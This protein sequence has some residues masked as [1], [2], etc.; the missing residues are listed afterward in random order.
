M[1]LWRRALAEVK[2]KFY[3]ESETGLDNSQ[4]LD[5]LLSSLRTAE[6]E[7]RRKE[8]RHAYLS[9]L[10]KRLILGTLLDRQSGD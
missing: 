10:R 3:E 2:T 4:A 7:E 6:T 9:P 5:A 8:E 1:E